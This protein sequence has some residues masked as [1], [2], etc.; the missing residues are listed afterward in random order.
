MF[1]QIRLLK[2]HYGFCSIIYWKKGE[3]KT[4]NNIKEFVLM[5]HR[6]GING[7]PFIACRSLQKI[8]EE[9]NELS[10]EEKAI[11]KESF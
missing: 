9:T 2:R 3:E 6:F 5:R 7:S 11:I 4:E 8:I 10:R 1:H